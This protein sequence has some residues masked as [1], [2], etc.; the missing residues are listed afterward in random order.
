MLLPGS[1]SPHLHSSVTAAQE[2][3][4]TTVVPASSEHNQGSPP[5]D[6]PIGEDIMSFIQIQRSQA[7]ELERTCKLPPCRLAHMVKEGIT[8]ASKGTKQATVQPSCV[9]VNPSSEKHGTITLRV[10]VVHRPWQ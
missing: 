6:L 1:L 7:P 9:P 4:G 8:Q 5:T 2:T 3:V 10:M